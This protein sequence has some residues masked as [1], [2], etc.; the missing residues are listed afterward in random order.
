MSQRLVK[1]IQFCCK[2]HVL[3]SAAWQSFCLLSPPPPDQKVS[4]YTSTGDLNYVTTY[5]RNVDMTHMKQTILTHPWFAGSYSVNI[6]SWR[7]GCRLLGRHTEQFSEQRNV[8]QI[9]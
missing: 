5:Y 6:L 9:L 3:R 1:N 4:S 8:H 7:L 2:K